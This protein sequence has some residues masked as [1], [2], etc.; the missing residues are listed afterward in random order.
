MSERH[1]HSRLRSRWTALLAALLVVV[2]I[3]LWATCGDD[4]E[5][6]TDA[7]RATDTGATDDTAADDSAV[8]VTDDSAS[9]DTTADDAVEVAEPTPAETFPTSLH[10]TRAG[11]RT[12][13][14]GTE[15]QPGFFS[16]TGVPYADLECGSCHATTYADGTD[17][18]AATYQPSCR[19]CHADPADPT[20]DIADSVCLGCHSRQAAEINLANAGNP[21]FSDVHRDVGYD[22]TYCHDA[23]EM[24]G[25]GTAYDS[26]LEAG[27]P[28]AACTD[29]HDPTLLAPNGAHDIH[30]REFNCS[31][32][33]MQ[34]VV[35]C[36]NCHFETEVAGF[37]KRFFG[38]PPLNGFIL[39]MNYRGQ[40]HPGTFQSLQFE[41]HSFVALAPFYG[42]TITIEGRTCSDCHAND[43]VTEYGTD[44][45]IQLTEWDEGGSTVNGP[46]GVVPVP[47]DYDTALLFD[48]L[49]YTGDDLS[50]RPALPE[51]WEFLESGPELMQLLYG[52][53]LSADQMSDLARAR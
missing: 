49:D 25:S 18:D 1:V 16:L 7:G 43:A 13:Y 5:G 3:A 41:E 6:E 9:D 52:E 8:E 20:D 47:P 19:D 50:E 22:C 28:R 2:P 48:F 53:P 32:C 51:S 21:S 10:A 38:P 31:S 14:E 36:N 33:H 29:C 11:K 37:G 46:S 27:A 30:G 23:G 15:D 26:M 34:S 44:G 45:T 4:D 24:H 40:V 42:H 35:A 17:V 12:F 39:L